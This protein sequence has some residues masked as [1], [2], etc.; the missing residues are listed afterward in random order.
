LQLQPL[1]NPFKYEQ[2]RKMIE[3]SGVTMVSRARILLADDHP[4]VLEHA[5][6][7]LAVRFEVVGVVSDGRAAV[8]ETL[9]L[10]PDLVVLDIMMPELDGFHAAREL[11][12]RGSDAKVVFLT[13][14]QN[15]EYIAAA[16]ESGGAA[17][18]LKSRMHS[19]LIPAIDRALEGS[20]CRNQSPEV[21]PDSS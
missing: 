20:M 14:Q 3:S 17:Y 4:G 18:V 5:S 12:R 8:N 7:I 13:I 19:D 15:E 2:P 10:K 16:L 11:R 6:R 1:L 9:R 21:I